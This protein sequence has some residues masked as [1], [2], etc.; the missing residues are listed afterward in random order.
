MK[1]RFFA[2]FLCMCILLSILSGC[3]ETPVE[4]TAPQPS[5]T[6]AVTCP[7]TQPAQ[8]TVDQSQPTE[9]SV[10]EVPTEP[11]EV[12]STEPEYSFVLTDNSVV[13]T[14]KGQRLNLYC[15]DVP[16]NEISW[17]SA[18]ES[19]A[20]FSQGQVVAM[21]KGI[22]VV[23][24]KYRDEIIFC[25][26]EC[27]VNLE[28]P[29]PYVDPKLLQ[30][31]RMG[32]PYVENPEDT[33]FFDNAVF[34][35][36]SVSY[37]LQQ[38]SLKHAGNFGDAVFL[39]RS[40]LGLQNTIDGR[41]QLSYQGI[42]Y[43]PEDAVA[44]VGAEKLFVML[45]FNDLALFGLE[46]TMERWGIFLGRILEKNP[47][48]QIYIQSCTPL[49]RDGEYDKLNNDLVDA[50]NQAL[51]DYCAENGYHFVNIAPYFMDYRNSL[52]G[53]YCTD[54]FMH[55]TY[56]GAVVWEYALKAYAASQ[57]TEGEKE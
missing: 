7:V 5:E 43:S 9:P 32:I 18:D 49:H 2:M 36:D 27:D 10:T 16:L 40:S 25:E 13:L 35:G 4:T 11:E 12:K 31:P 50:Y 21:D 38:W 57:Q 52:V 55:I 24:A 46:G 28:D 34:I 14:E 29:A 26:V 3:A 51:K 47:D 56:D 42:S 1:Q 30:A 39:C 48:I 23:Y 20:L 15:G 45:G 33:S 54:N 44:A 17:M 6:E 22:T 8:E 19:I 41:L 37:V 53:T